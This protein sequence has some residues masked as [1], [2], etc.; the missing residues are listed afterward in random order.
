MFLSQEDLG[1]S[2][3]SFYAGNL[4]KWTFAPRGCAVLWA[5]PERQASLRPLVTS[6]LYKRGYQDEFFQQV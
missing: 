6:N 4:H 1:R 5:H 3:V 2:G